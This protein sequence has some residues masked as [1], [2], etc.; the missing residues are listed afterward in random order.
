[1]RTFK[2]ECAQFSFDKCPVYTHAGTRAKFSTNET[3]YYVAKQCAK[4]LVYKEN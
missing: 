1:M 3:D 4:N 2:G